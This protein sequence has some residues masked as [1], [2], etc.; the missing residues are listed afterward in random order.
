M[1]PSSK[2]LVRAR[3]LGITKTLER[4]PPAEKKNQIALQLAKDFNAALSAV[5][6]E[7]PVIAQSLP[8][9]LTLNSPFRQIGKAPASYLDLEI[10]CEQ[11]LTLLDLVGE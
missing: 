6:S 1:P 11:V 10:A 9:E 4:T 2:E 5:A 7:F 3:L 8:G